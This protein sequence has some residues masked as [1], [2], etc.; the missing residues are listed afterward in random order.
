MTTVTLPAPNPAL[1]RSVAEQAQALIPQLVQ[2]RRHLHTHPELGWQEAATT[3]YVARHVEALGFD[4]KT[5]APVIGSKTLGAPAEGPAHTGCIAELHFDRPG[6][7][8]A[9]RADLDALPIHEVDTQGQ[10]HRPAEEGWHSQ[11]TGVMHACGHDGHLAIALGIAQIIA[12]QKAHLCGTLRLIF[13]PAEEGTRGAR[14][15]VE[16]G[17]LDDVDVFLGFHIGLGVPS[18]T[19]ALDPVGFLATRKYSV[20]YHGAPAHAGRAPETG[21]N[22]LLGACQATLGLHALAQSGQPGIRVNV[23]TMHA[24]QALNIVP[25]EARF[26]VELRAERQHDLDALDPRVQALIT[27]TAAAHQLEADIRLIG[28]ARDWENPADMVAWAREVAQCSGAFRDTVSRYDVRV[29][30]DATLMTHA[31]AARGGK[32]A[33]MVLGADLPSGHHTAEFDFDEGVLG[34]GVALVGGMVGVV[35]GAG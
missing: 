8:V 18:D 3:A 4:I 11:H 16:Q 1:V 13:Q 27:G 23:G 24:G 22:A 5:G 30:E 25:D 10:G 32:A 34:K 2:W 21:R 28:E 20:T 31:V 14:A 33:Y 12:T 6:P 17:W 9:I 15:I 7:T 26:G 35:L 29:S 19:V